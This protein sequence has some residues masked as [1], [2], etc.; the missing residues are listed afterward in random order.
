VCG[1]IKISLL[2][3]VGVQILSPEIDMVSE[4]RI[5][6][7][8]GI[9]EAAAAKTV[10]LSTKFNMTSPHPTHGLEILKL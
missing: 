5:C 1:I 10:D 9:T 2:T 6:L 7:L 3:I 4:M 8:F